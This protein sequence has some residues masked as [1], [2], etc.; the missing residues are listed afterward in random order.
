VFDPPG[1]S[2]FAVA[3]YEGD[4]PVA[5]LSVTK[6][7]SPDPVQVGMPLTYTVAVGNE[8]PGDDP[9]VRMIDQLPPDSDAQFL[10]AET[11]QRECRERRGQVTCDLGSLAAGATATVTIV[12][13]PIGN[14][15]VLVNTARVVGAGIDENPGNNADT[16]ETVV[17]QGGP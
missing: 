7:D 3:R 10:S 2:D 16:E 17:R 13:R 1:D 6:V 15:D 8:G 11:T 14:M 12:V 5:D 4:P 9:L